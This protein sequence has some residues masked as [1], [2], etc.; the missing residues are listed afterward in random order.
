MRSWPDF[1]VRDAL[2][3]V[4][5]AW[6]VGR[7]VVMAVDAIVRVSFQTNVQA[8]Q[9]AN[10]ALVGHTQNAQGTGPFTRVGTAAYGCNGAN[11]VDVTASLAA[12]GAAL[13]QFATYVDFVSISLVRR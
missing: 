11:D 6:I 5:L 1:M 7:L 13:A 9:A 10:S 12:L 3:L 4:T 2:R 8:N